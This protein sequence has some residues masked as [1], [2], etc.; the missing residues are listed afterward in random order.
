LDTSDA[1]TPGSLPP[2]TLLQ[3][4]EVTRRLAAR[5]DLRTLLAEIVEAAQAV[6]RSER[7]TVWLYEADSGTLVLSG[8]DEAEK[9]RVSIKQGLLGRSAVLGK[10]VNVPDCSVDPHFDPEADLDYDDDVRCLL[11]IPLVDGGVLVGVM[12]VVDKEDGAFTELDER[13]A[14]TL[15]AHCVVAIQ[16]ERMTEALVVA[17]KLDREIKL[18]REI[19]FSTLPAEMPLFPGYDVAAIFQPA[20]QT[21][22]DTY[23]LVPLDEHRMFMLLGDASGHGIGPALSAT[24]MTAMLRVALRLGAELDALFTQVNNQ[25]I[26]DLPEEHFIT[27]FLG[28]LDTRNHSVCYFSG[29]QGPLLHYRAATGECVWHPPSTYPLGFMA[30]PAL[31]APE[32]I[33]FAPGDVLGLISDGVYEYQD[34]QGRQF[35]TEG[36]AGVI[37]Q[38]HERPMAELLAILLEATREFAG[39]S[40][41]LDDVTVVLLRRTRDG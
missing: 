25:L 5:T 34:A 7:A 41:Q 38:H 11:S 33:E 36:V 3:I 23:D 28:M 2:E 29:G 39:G 35:G 16:R 19:Q 12:Q 8:A 30:Y 6:L 37:S 10:V 31:K 18:A 22:G 13:I 20:D 21:G 14:A 32:C 9:R 15:A 17:E 24:Q 4:L 40:P 26:E 27:A 1:I